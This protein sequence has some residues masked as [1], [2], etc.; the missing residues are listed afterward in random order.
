MNI[1]MI[2]RTELYLTIKDYAAEIAERKH[3]VSSDIYL[4]VNELNGIIN[5]EILSDVIKIECIEPE[6]HT[7][8]AGYINSLSAKKY[9]GSLT[10]TDKNIN[11]EAINRLKLIKRFSEYFRVLPSNRSGTILTVYVFFMN[12]RSVLDP[13]YAFNA[14]FD[15]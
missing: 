15:D 4:A 10:F 5:G 7:L 1:K 2:N 11:I 14:L 6:I 3:N 9:I 12:E 8:L 13:E